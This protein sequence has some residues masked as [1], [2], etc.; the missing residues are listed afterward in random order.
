[1]EGAHVI[2]RRFAH[3]I[4][5]AALCVLGACN[6]PNPQ[7]ENEVAAL[8]AGASNAGDA[9]PPPI[10]TTDPWPRQIQTGTATLTI[11]SPQVESWTGNLLTYRAAV[12]VS[13]PGTNQQTYGVIWGQARTEVDR[14]ARMVTLEDQKLTR[15]NFPTLPDNG[16]SYLA[17]VA[18]QIPS[19]TRTIALARI[20]ASLAA[21]SVAKPTGVAVKNPVPKIIVS[22]APSFLVPIDGAPVVRRVPGQSFERVINTRALII[23]ATGA[24][25]WFMH[26]YDGW[27]EAPAITG[28]WGLAM[29]MPPGLG[30][31]AQ[32]LA[33]NGQTDLLTGSNAQPPPS[34]GNDVPAVFVS[35]EPAELIVFKGQ[36]ELQ[37]ITGTSL[38]WCT[39]TT[40]DVIVDETNGS[41]YLLISGRWYKSGAL[42]GPWSYV[43]SQNL[44]VDFV[45]IP[46]GSPAGVVLAAVAGTPQ[47]REAVISNSIPQTANIPLSSPPAF[48]ATYDGAPKLVPISGTTLSY[49]ANSPTPVIRVGANEWYALRAGVWFTSTSATGPWFVARAVPAAIYTIP[50]S[51]PIH[52]VTYV[53]IYGATSETVYVG[54]TPGYLGTVVAPDGVVVYGTGYDYDP[55]VG[56]VWYAPPETY[57]IAAQPIYSPVLGYSYGYGMGLFTP[58]VVGA[59]GV[60]YYY[61]SAYHGY[62]CCGSASANVYGHYGATNWSGTKTAYDTGTSVGVKSSGSFDNTRTGTTGTYSGYR[63]YDYDTN[64]RAA[65]AS[66]TR[67]TAAGG[68]NTRSASGSYNYD[69]GRYSTNRQTSGTTAGGSDYSHS[70]TTT[71][72]DGAPPSVDRDSSF[73]SAKTGQTYSTGTGDRGNNLYASPSGEVQQNGANGWQKATSNGWQSAGGDNSWADRESQGRSQAES[74]ASGGGLGGG[75]GGFGGGGGGWGNHFGGSGGGGFGDRFGE[76]GGG[77]HGGGSRG[78]GFGGGGFRGGGRR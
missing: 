27:L 13:T 5:V 70:V 56:N 26:L 57:G 50:P 69:N 14:E 3:A 74:S 33:S 8:P 45:S 22:Y 41:Y 55:W 61:G 59:W 44:P 25:T 51:S 48:S 15:S 19:A 16:A 76:G 29:S 40:S 37:P 47:A 12:A 9:P 62:P 78:G 39:N 2:T 35:R 7:L 75:S 34:L 20:E 52:Y 23:R 11:Y 31:L 72:G 67:D 64:T 36:P 6:S 63:N 38:L 60:P 49:V 4:V 18:A 32:T 24:S 46:P 42:T 21:S 73:T 66:V 1:M 17:E 54:Y 43:P 68:T 71:G 30:A 28:P 53:Q 65:G 58:V 77:F 10:A